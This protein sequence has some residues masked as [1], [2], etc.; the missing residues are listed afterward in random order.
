MTE[1]KKEDVKVE[2]KE[3]F[4]DFDGSGGR[5]ST[6]ILIPEDSYQGVVSRVD[7]IESPVYNKPGQLQKK[8][9]IQVQLHGEGSEDAELPLFANPVIKKSGG[10]KG[11]SNS[12]LYDVLESANVLEEAKGAHEA[13]ETFEGLVGFLDA[14]LK[15]RKCKALVSTVNK[16]SDNAYSTVK[17]ILRF[18]P[19]S[20]EKPVSEPVVSDVTPEARD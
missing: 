4:V 2:R 10:T 16:G 12:K 5:V 11:Y 18:E 17:N 13:L 8:V 20:P 3:V 14:R 9:V 1:E 19:V 7:L 15:G 6:K